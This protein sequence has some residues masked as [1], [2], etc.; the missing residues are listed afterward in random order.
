MKLINLILIL[1]LL[2]PFAYAE[3]VLIKTT[4]TLNAVSWISPDNQSIMNIDIKT[5]NIDGDSN[6]TLNNI[7]AVENREFVISFVKDLD[8][9]NTTLGKIEDYF[10]ECDGN[11][12]KEMYIS[13]RESKKLVEQN[14]QECDSNLATCNSEKNSC[15]SNITDY[16]TKFN[17]AQTQVEQ[18]NE[19]R[20]GMVVSKDLDKVKNEKWYYLGGLILLLILFRNNIVE[21]YLN[22]NFYRKFK[23]VKGES[24]KRIPRESLDKEAEEEMKKM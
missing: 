24:D 10:Q 3:D 14:K 19:D 16:Q 13:C 7:V 20:A 21:W 8:C 4:I 2:I 9:G 6:L 17:E 1:I 11:D 15:S 12:C 18:C 23:G 22:S 5:S